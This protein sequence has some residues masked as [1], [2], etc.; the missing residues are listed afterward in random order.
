M[1][2]RRAR[3]PGGCYFFTVVTHE[4]HPRLA[5]AAIRRNLGDAMRRVQGRHPFRLNA[6]V[7]LPD[8]LHCIWTLPA[9]DA[10]FSLRWRLIKRHVTRRGHGAR[11][12]Q[13]RFWEH[14]IRNEKD[15]RDHVDYIHYNPVKHDL[16]PAP[17]W[18]PWSS[19]H[20]YVRDGLYPPDWGQTE[21]DLPADV[22]Q[23]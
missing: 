11:I 5:D 12:W 4:R 18:W 9:G 6:I 17:K 14:L 20:G 10:D 23:E 13:G 1:R 2:Y 3:T 16:A 15:L 22:G 8:H 19:F 21:P 7:L